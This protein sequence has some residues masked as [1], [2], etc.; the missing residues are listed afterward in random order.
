MKQNAWKAVGAPAYIYIFPT[1]NNY[2][3]II[4]IGL[5]LRLANTI[6]YGSQCMGLHLSIFILKQHANSDRFY[7]P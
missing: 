3:P 2:S 5:I 6:I 4:S 7:L 1:L